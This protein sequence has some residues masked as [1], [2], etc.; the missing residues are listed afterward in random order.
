[1][2]IKC[3]TCNEN[4][5]TCP[6]TRVH[7]HVSVGTC[8]WTRVH[9][10]VSMDTC[11]WT[12][13]RVHGHVSMGTRRWTFVHGHIP[14][15]FCMF[16]YFIPGSVAAATARPRHP[17]RTTPAARRPVSLVASRVAGLALALAPLLARRERRPVLWRSNEVDFC[18]FQ[19]P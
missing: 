15:I 14:C 5:H 1:M 16:L 17:A 19:S 13:V 3:K 7:G 9:G 12:R 11:A 6:W 18:N 8:L 10:L 4:A 2:Q